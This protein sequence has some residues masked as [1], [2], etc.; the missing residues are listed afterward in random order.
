M[1]D[2]NLSSYAYVTPPVFENPPTVLQLLIIMLKNHLLE[3]H[4]INLHVNPNCK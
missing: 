3:I 1:V 4:L 2:S